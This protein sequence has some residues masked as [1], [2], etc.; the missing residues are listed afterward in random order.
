[1]NWYNE[2]SASK[3][4]IPQDIKDRYSSASF[5][6]DNLVIFNIKGN[7]YRLVVKIAY[8]TQYLRQIEFNCKIDF[9]NLI[10]SICYDSNIKC[11]YLNF[12]IGEGVK[13]RDSIY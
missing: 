4:K 10:K 12:E 13:D 11:F 7:K 6:S 8:K 1:M 9:F 2:A 5:L 3:W